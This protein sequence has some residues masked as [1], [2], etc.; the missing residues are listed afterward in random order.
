MRTRRLTLFLLLAILIPYNFQVYTC[1]TSSFN[2]Q[3]SLSKQASEGK[4]IWQ[5]RNC[6]SCHQIYGLGGYLGPDLTNVI[7]KKGLD[8]ARTFIETGTQKMPNLHLNKIEIEALLAYLS[9]IDSS[10]IY[11]IKNFE[12]NWDGTLT[13][14]EK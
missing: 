6:A 2:N 9:H 1:W 3:N 12:P 8:Y 5:E 13:H 7:S 11:P 10:G 4:S 14:N